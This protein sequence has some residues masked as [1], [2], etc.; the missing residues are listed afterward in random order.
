MRRGSACSFT[1]DSKRG[2]G[3]GGGGVEKEGSYLCHMTSYP[4]DISVSA[5]LHPKC[6]CWSG[7]K[8][9]V[10]PL[11]SSVRGHIFL[12]SLTVR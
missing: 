7:V 4:F 6:L 9:P 12:E 3:R 5:N 11:P 8:F 10:T 1:W 2:R